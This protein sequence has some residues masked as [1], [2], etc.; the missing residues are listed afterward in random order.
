M[1]KEVECCVCH[2]V[3]PH[4]ARGM[5]DACYVREY[6]KKNSRV[7]VSD[8]RREL[9]STR[10]DAIIATLDA[11]ESKFSEIGFTCSFSYWDGGITI[12]V[13]GN[14]YKVVVE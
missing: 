10:E 14:V 2:E 4:R 13:Q 7:R 5:C 12:D 1:V 11:L 8:L 3:K 9:E 6:R